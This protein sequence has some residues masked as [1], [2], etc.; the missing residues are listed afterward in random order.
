M[1]KKKESKKEKDTEKKKKAK[2]KTK[3]KKKKSKDKKKKEEV[4]EEKKKKEKKEDKKEKEEA[5]K[6]KGEEK[7]EEKE[8][9]EKEEIKIE[10][11]E[12]YYEAV[13]KRKTATAIIR[14][15]TK[16]KKEFL[17]NEKMAQ[18][19][20]PTLALQKTALASFEKMNC[21]D[22]FRVS[23]LVRGGGLSA[24]AEAVRHASARALTEFNP[25]FRKK[26][27]KAGYLRRDSRM[28]ERK[29]PGLRGARRAP[30]WGKR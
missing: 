1:A 21:L 13:G 3:T 20:F 17:V 30:Q 27:K 9:E 25:E 22:K 26:L 12:G 14:V 6:E 15:W 24:Q 7:K 16:G 4:K 19:Y 11:K 28:K 2:T 29:K 10:E 5:K 8:K 23:V 18:E